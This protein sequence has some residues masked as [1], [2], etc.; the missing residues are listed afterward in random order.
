MDEQP[1]PTVPPRLRTVCYVLGAVLGLAAA[2][3]LLALDLPQWAGVAAACA[4]AA[5]ALALGYRPTR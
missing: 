4:G 5:N 2:P 1:T 3:S